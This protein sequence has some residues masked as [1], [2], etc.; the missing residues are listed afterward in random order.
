MTTG[1][2]AAKWG[3][4]GGLQCDRDISSGDP[5]IA[6]KTCTCIAARQAIHTT[7]LRLNLLTS[8]YQLRLSSSFLSRQAAFVRARLPSA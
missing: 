6:R 2:I 1:H 5:I 7:S 3:H 8:M 4:I